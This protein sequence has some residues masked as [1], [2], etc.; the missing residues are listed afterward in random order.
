MVSPDFLPLTSGGGLHEEGGPSLIL[1][2]VGRPAPQI[3][4]WMEAQALVSFLGDSLYRAEE[5]G[6]FSP[7]PLHRCL[8]WLFQPGWP[9][10]C[11]S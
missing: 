11:V 1:E 9:R 10:A 6:C 4:R 2:P 7:Q 5:Q 8:G 3:P